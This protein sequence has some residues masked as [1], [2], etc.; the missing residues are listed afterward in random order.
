MPPLVPLSPQSHPNKDENEFD[1]NG[2][3]ATHFGNVPASEV[4]GG[5]RGGEL[6]WR[7]LNELND[8]EQAERRQRGSASWRPTV[9][10]EDNQNFYDGKRGPL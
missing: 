9:A 2:V 10:F 8:N 4:G 7:K 5:M 1:W 6:G 3:I